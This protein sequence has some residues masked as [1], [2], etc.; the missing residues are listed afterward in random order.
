MPIAL[1]EIPLLYPVGAAAGS[2]AL[3]NLPG[4]TM[5]GTSYAVGGLV[6]APRWRIDT[7]AA[8]T[9]GGRITDVPSTTPACPG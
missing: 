7:K 9:S 6:G 4:A 2:T 8:R 1:L 5:A 3:D